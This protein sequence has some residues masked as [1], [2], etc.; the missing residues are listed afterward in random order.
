MI[1]AEV[2]ADA[3][4]VDDVDDGWF[5]LITTVVKYCD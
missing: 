4:D 1:D 2:G 5:I 3:D